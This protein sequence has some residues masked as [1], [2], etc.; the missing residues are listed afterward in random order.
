MAAKLRF[1]H[2]QRNCP[3]CARSS[4]ERRRPSD[5]SRQAGKNG[6]KGVK[7]EVH[8]TQVEWR[9]NSDSES[10]VIGL[11]TRQVLSAVDTNEADS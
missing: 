7:N 10:D 4:A 3:E 1:G 9:S 6:K 5:Y 8:Q 2:I 11:V